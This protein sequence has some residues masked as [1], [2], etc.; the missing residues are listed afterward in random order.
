MRRGICGCLSISFGGVNFFNLHQHKEY[1]VKVLQRTPQNRPKWSNLSRIRSGLMSCCTMMDLSSWPE[2]VYQANKKIGV[3]PVQSVF[4][5]KAYRSGWKLFGESFPSRKKILPGWNFPKIGKD[6]RT[7]VFIETMQKLNQA[8]SNQVSKWDTLLGPFT[9]CGASPRWGGCR[10]K[11]SFR[12][13]HIFC[14]L[15]YCVKY[16]CRRQRPMPMQVQTLLLF[17]SLR[18]P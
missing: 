17:W 12:S 18:L 13:W 8:Y 10:H 4:G 16:P 5:A 3:L 15:D 14:V 11:Y 7:H 6:G 9:S 2:A 1:T